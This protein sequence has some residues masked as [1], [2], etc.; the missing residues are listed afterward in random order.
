M[1]GTDFK[2]MLVVVAKAPLPGKVKTRFLT[3]LT[4]A[5]AAGLYRCFIRDRVNE[6]RLLQGVELAIAF[7]PD[8]S[9]TYFTR[10]LNEGFRL[11]P[12]HGVDLGERLSNIFLQKLGEGYQTVVI[13]DS[14]T[15]DLP[16]SLVAQAFHWLA[17]KSVDAV[18]GPCEDGGYY[19]VGMRQA[20]REL[21]TDIPWSTA[22][23]LRRSLQK[24][25]SLGLNIRL[26]PRWND[27]DTVDDLLVYYHKYQQF[28]PDE[29]L[30]GKETFDCLKRLD[31]TARR[32]P[33]LTPKAG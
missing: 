25:A 24:A 19:L 7:T 28:D 14:D 27:L 15:P 11:F 32:E 33:P 6:F 8:E 10:F 31:I 1:P 2:K 26:L 29:Q 4:P 13:I 3:Q 22:N 17:S 5:E 9:E 30:I 12:Q 18:F 20:Q 23:V 21:F 16:N